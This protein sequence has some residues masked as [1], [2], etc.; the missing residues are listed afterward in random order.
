MRLPVA[1]L[2]GLSALSAPSA[3]GMRGAADAKPRASAQEASATRLAF[4]RGKLIYAY[5]RAAWQGSDDLVAKMPDYA[6]KVGGWI[7]D[8][9][10]EAPQLVFYDKNEADPHAVFIARFKDRQLQSSQV[11]GASDDRNLS[12]QRKSM[13]AARLA[14]VAALATA[15]V[16]RCKEQ[17]F[18]TVVLP[19]ERPGAATLVYIMTP[20]SDR[21][22]IPMGGHYLVE[23]AADGSAGKPR[24]FTKTCLE[25]PFADAKGGRPEALVV[26]HLLD[27]VPT[28]M[29]VFSSFAAGLPIYVSTENG[30]VWAVNAAGIR[31]V[32]DKRN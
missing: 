26:S 25:M 32:R 14:A 15:G 31:I 23:V 19:P 10:A 27:P 13:I 2:I 5:D 18:N 8:G 24:P 17:P 11:L 1:M 9:P 7:V 29:H 30:R 3:P 4:E 20:Q 16:G 21:K 12:P 28:E 6:S 22:A